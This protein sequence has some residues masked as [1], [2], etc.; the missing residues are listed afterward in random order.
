MRYSISLKINKILGTC[1]VKLKKNPPYSL[2]LKFKSLFLN[3]YKKKKINFNINSRFNFK[4][5]NIYDSFKLSNTSN[6]VSAY[7]TA[8]LQ[9]IGFFMEIKKISNP[10]QLDSTWL[11]ELKKKI[12]SFN[13]PFEIQK[14]II[15]KYNSIS[16]NFA[17]LEK[18][19]FQINESP[20][21][22]VEKSQINDIFFLKN[23]KHPSLFAYNPNTIEISNDRT[24]D[25]FKIKRIR[26]KPGY[27]RIWRNAR[28]VLAGI[29]HL[30]HKYQY[31][32]TRHISKYI[33]LIKTPFLFYYE[34]KLKN[35]ILYSQFF[36]HSDLIDLNIKA[37][38]IFI[39]SFITVNPDFQ[40]Y[41]NDFIQLIVHVK[42]YLIF[43]IFIEQAHWKK[44]KIKVK[45][46]KQEKMK[47]FDSDI[48]NFKK[49]STTLPK[50]IIFHDYWSSDIPS[51]LEIDYMTLS[52]YVIYDPLYFFT[53][54]NSDLLRV[55]YG[56]M[57]MYNWKYIV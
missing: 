7:N 44:L 17:V 27:M 48:E 33:Y 1:L 24:D 28:K 45:L 53:H 51:F 39:N 8:F 11:S 52:A 14:K 29:M 50:W 16:E 9:P 20:S 10:N 49:P 26:F 56:I 42:Y 6:I 4:Y 31:R 55:R 57:N 37:G 22:Y 46:R 30:Q 35:V 40:I 12:Y 36:V 54:S 3:S 32:L 2:K 43:R 25:Y 18:N 19:D 34:M 15:S 41:K 21:P 5:G 38:N 47:Q 23:N 13:E